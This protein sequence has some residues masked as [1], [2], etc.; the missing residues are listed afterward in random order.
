M[1]PFPFVRFAL[2]DLISCLEDA[3]EVREEWGMTCFQ[4]RGWQLAEGSD[5]GFTAEGAEMLEWP[6]QRAQQLLDHHCTL[7]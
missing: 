2:C 4:L 3:Q 6:P 1:L 5:G 7:I